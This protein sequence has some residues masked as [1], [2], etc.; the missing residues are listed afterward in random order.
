MST[1]IGAAP[2]TTYRQAVTEALRDEMRSDPSVV[3][4]GEDVGTAGGVFK[5]TE[6]L[7]E[8][9]GPGR[10]RDTP[11]SEMAI[12]GAALGAAL[13]GLRPVVELMFADFVGVAM[14]QLALQIPKYRYMTGGQVKVPLVIRAVAGAGLGFAAQHSGSPEAWF[15]HVPGWRIVAPSTPADAY[16]LLRAAIRCDD[17]VLFFEHKAL[18]AR[19]G[20]LDRSRAAVIGRAA[21]VRE[22]DDVTVVAVS[23]MVERALTAAE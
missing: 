2:D 5:V 7:L 14:D 22:G 9:F 17:P 4:L 6:G 16:A 11:I 18:Y 10:V 15:M 20:W 21:V 1:A 12:V 13:N 19:K 8:E 23:M 3:L